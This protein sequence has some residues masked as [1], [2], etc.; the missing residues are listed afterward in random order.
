MLNP[1]EES[2]VDRFIHDD[3]YCAQEKHN[4]R[5]ILIR[6]QDTQIEGIN[7]KGLL[8]GLPETVVK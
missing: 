2:E 4:G 6:K 7:K 5:H 1:I 8:V 3:N